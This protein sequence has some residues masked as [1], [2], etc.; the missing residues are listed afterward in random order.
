M[1]K[2]KDLILADAIRTSIKLSEEIII[3]KRIIAG[4]S[5]TLIALVIILIKVA[6]NG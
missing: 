3:L 4:L 1:K 2:A 5:V 6:A